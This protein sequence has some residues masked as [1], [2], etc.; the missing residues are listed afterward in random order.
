MPSSSSPPPSEQGASAWP[1]N[2]VAP[3]SS[4]GVDSGFNAAPIPTCVCPGTN[5][6]GDRK[7]SMPVGRYFV[8]ISNALKELKKWPA[9]PRSFSTPHTV[10]AGFTRIGLSFI[11]AHWISAT[12]P[13][14]PPGKIRFGSQPDDSYRKWSARLPRPSLHSDKHVGRHLNGHHHRRRIGGAIGHHGGVH[15]RLSAVRN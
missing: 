6:P 3:L 2:S 9:F 1:A 14:S 15:Q 11:L 7:S 10:I 5:P 13:P 12:Q 8:A 4:L